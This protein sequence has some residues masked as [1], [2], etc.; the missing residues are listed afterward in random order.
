MKY[1]DQFAICQCYLLPS[2]SPPSTTSRVQDWSHW[3]W[4]WT[5]DERTW[6][7][8]LPLPV[9]MW[10]PVVSGCAGRGWAGLEKQQN[11]DAVEEQ[12]GYCIF[13]LQAGGR[14]VGVGGFCRLV[15]VSA[16]LSC[17]SKFYKKWGLINCEFINCNMIS[18]SL[19]FQARRSFSCFST[20]GISGF[21]HLNSWH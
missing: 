3:W 12:T 16:G 13:P 9:C 4:C 10:K 18:F 8:V 2:S 21:I 14:R 1:K 6:A 5:E 11:Q 17:S 7:G 19:Y 20:W 15:G